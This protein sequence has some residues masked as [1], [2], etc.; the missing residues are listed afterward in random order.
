[1]GAAAPE[2]P[3][4]RRASANTRTLDPHP[5]KHKFRNAKRAL[6]SGNSGK[7]F[8]QNEHEKAKYDNETGIV[9]D[10]SVADE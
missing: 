5:A 1:M 9:G 4:R 8:L 2:N 7:G 3:V 10:V 6:I